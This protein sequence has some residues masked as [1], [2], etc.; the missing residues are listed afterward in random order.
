MVTEYQKAFQDR[1]EAH[2][3]VFQAIQRYV[4]VGS[5][6]SQKN[7]M[8]RLT[9][10]QDIVLVHLGKLINIFWIQSFRQRK[11]LIRPYLQALNAAKLV[12]DDVYIETRHTAISEKVS[13]SKLN[14]IDEKYQFTI[15]EWIKGS[16][17]LNPNT[18]KENDT[19]FPR[20]KD[21]NKVPMARLYALPNPLLEDTLSKRAKQAA[22]SDIKKIKVSTSRNGLSPE[23]EHLLGLVFLKAQFELKMRSDIDYPTKGV[24][25]WYKVAEESINVI[26]NDILDV[27]AREVRKLLKDGDKVVAK[28][29]LDLH[30]SYLRRFASL[31][32]IRNFE[33]FVLFSFFS[34]SFKQGRFGSERNV[35]GINEVTEK[36]YT[37]V[38]N[39]GPDNLEDQNPL[40]YVSN[41]GFSL[42]FGQPDTGDSLQLVPEWRF[43]GKGLKEE[44]IKERHEKS[45]S[46]TLAGQ[47]QLVIDLLM[48][49]EVRLKV[50]D[51]FKKHKADLKT[52]RELWTKK[53]SIDLSANEL[54]TLVWE[55]LFEKFLIEDK[56]TA[57][58]RLSNLMN[59][60]LKFFTRHTY[61]NIS[62]NHPEKYLSQRWPTDL[63]ES[64]FFDCGVYITR[65]AYDIYKAIH[66]T[67]VTVEFRYLTFLNHIAL[68]GFIDGKSFLINNDLI[69]KP[70]PIKGNKFQK[71]GASFDWT[72]EA[73]T[74]IYDLDFAIF[75]SVL[76]NVDITTNQSEKS[77]IRNLLSTYK[78]SLFW[79]I[80]N[81]I[82]QQTKGNPSYFDDIN[83]FNVDSLVLNRLIKNKNDMNKSSTSIPITQATQLTSDL[84]RIAK[85]IAD[86]DNYVAQGRIPPHSVKIDGAFRLSSND[87][88]RSSLPMY[89][90]VEILRKK[91]SLSSNQQFLVG[92]KIGLEHIKQLN[93]DF[94]LK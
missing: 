15:K 52:S 73:Y 35:I 37:Y 63:T 70:R 21:L 11:A 31:Y 40:G 89:N 67:D 41:L 23:T 78:K 88:G 47:L 93:K 72:G 90:F 26:R 77:F 61:Y 30:H 34:K 53:N 24:E 80:K 84:Y 74:T 94:I 56:L 17:L 60:Y 32:S 65:M 7:R 19:F 16:P 75:L 22:E 36:V 4:T 5:F 71:I 49:D 55:V 81:E 62:D 25:F 39:S 48:H 10:F 45:I 50:D 1:M 79:G 57:F 13:E 59:N 33:T 64:E 91:Q 44:D 54:R 58:E 43:V 18:N 76:I 9:K 12:C 29:F 28:R 8:S 2:E 66:P 86:K 46:D 20:I 27:F 87:P 14:K 85:V 3:K 68:V 82:A 69:F 42:R 38:G 83:K 6:R 92:Q 51:Y